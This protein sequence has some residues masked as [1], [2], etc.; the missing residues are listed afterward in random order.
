MVQ[1]VERLLIDD[2]FALLPPDP[3]GMRS[4]LVCGRVVMSPPTGFRHGYLSVRIA[5]QLDEFADRHDLGAVTV[6]SGFSFTPDRLNVRAPDVSF[7][8]NERLAQVTIREQGYTLLAPDLCVEVLSPGNTAA[9]MREKV[10]LYLATGVQRVWL[11][12]GQRKT[13]TVHRPGAAPETLGAGDTLT[14][15]DAG[16]GVEGFFLSLGQLFQST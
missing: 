5:R 11:V 2:E 14:S 1:V 16:F 9:A 7:T 6:G 12:D 8:S 3:D 15:D 13:V 4:E 10:A